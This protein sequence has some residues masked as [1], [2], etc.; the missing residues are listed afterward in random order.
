[1]FSL[2]FVVSLFVLGLYLLILRRYRLASGAWK[3]DDRNDARSSNAIVFC[4]IAWVIAGGFI[5]G[6]LFVSWTN[7]LNNF[8]VVKKTQKQIALFE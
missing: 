4:I 7:Q 3:K 1:M 5:I 6:S 2:I 8:S